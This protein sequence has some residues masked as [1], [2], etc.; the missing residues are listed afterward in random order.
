MSMQSHGATE[1]R[2][3]EWLV[4]AARMYAMC[5]KAEMPEPLSPVSL[6]LAA[7]EDVPLKEAAEFVRRN[8]ANLEDL[9]WAFTNSDSPEDFESKLQER[10]SKMKS[11][12]RQG[13]KRQS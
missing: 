8:Q 12:R 2:E 10:L 5:R 3:K 13:G 4:K 1:S 6:A 9:A 7:F 11:P